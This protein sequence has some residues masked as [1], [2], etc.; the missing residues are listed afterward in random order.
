[1]YEVE[2]CMGWRCLR[3]VEVY[4][5]DGLYLE[6]WRYMS[7]SGAWGGVSLRQMV[8]ECTLGRECVMGGESLSEEGLKGR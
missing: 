2:V 1:M 8:G 7:L 5:V 4:L 6:D 3:G